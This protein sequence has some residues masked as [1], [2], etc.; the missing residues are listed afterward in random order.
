[1][2][3]VEDEVYVA[4]VMGCTMGVLR[5]PLA[6]LRPGPD[7]DLFFNGSRQA[8]R[9]MD[10][11]VRAVRWQRIAP[12]YPASSGT[13]HISDEVLTDTWSFERGQ[14]WQKDLVGQTAQQGAPACISRN[15]ALPHVASSGDKPFVFASRFPNGAI[16][17]G[18]QERTHTGR[19]WYMPVSE[20]ELHVGDAPGPYGIFGNFTMLTLVLDRSLRGRRVIAQDLAGDEAIEVTDRVH[21]D[22]RSL[23]L[24]EANL[25]S[26][27]LQAATEG[28]LSSPGLV[29]TL[30]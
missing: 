4:A 25:R 10:E 20:V 19:A 3:N 18:S 9:R 13:V 6:G 5:H 26:F 22:G 28:D 17:I 15:I 16:A 21:M 8:K 27:G 29:F 7:M 24:T 30:R 12:P 11:V 1:L 2:L 14:T 23:Q